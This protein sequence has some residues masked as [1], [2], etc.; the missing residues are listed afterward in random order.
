MERIIPRRVMNGLSGNLAHPRDVKADGRVFHPGKAAEDILRLQMDLSAERTR[1][2]IRLVT[3]ID[4]R[5][6]AGR[7]QVVSH[8][9]HA[10]QDPGITRLDAAA[11]PQP[12]QFANL[13]DRGARG[14][15]FPQQCAY[16]V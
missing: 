8:L 9:V 12:V 7:A 4:Q 13:G 10:A 11:E 2:E 1:V 3:G 16:R 6:P 5:L 14:G 15:S